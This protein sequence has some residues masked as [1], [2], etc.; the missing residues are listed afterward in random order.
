MSPDPLDLPGNDDDIPVG[1]PPHC[2]CQPPQADTTGDPIEA[3]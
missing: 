3:P 1:E 2:L